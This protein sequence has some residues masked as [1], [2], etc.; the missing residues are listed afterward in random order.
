M[1]SRVQGLNKKNVGRLKHAF[2]LKKIILR[3]DVHLAKD[4]LLVA[5]RQII[6]S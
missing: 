4:H 6:L 3:Q 1:V 5:D 2:G